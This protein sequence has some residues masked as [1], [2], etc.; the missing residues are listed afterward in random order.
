MNP[1]AYQ[2]LPAPIQETG[3]EINSTFVPSNSSPIFRYN[4]YSVVVEE[5]MET[6][7]PTTLSRLLCAGHAHEINHHR[8]FIVNELVLYIL[9]LSITSSKQYMVLPL[10]YYR[11]DTYNYRTVS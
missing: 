1:P 9:P 11:S 2:A 8:W 7:C 5:E 10:K 3:R 6:H 4:K